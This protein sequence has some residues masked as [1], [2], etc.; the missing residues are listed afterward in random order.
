MCV[1]ESSRKIRLQVTYDNLAKSDTQSTCSKLLREKPAHRLCQWLET[2]KRKL[3]AERR[4]NSVKNWRTVWW[5]NASS[6][7]RSTQKK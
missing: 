2:R 1:A 3:P 5:T 7:R 4:L 6:M